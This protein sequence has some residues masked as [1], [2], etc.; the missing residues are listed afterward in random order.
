ML[1]SE[2]KEGRQTNRGKWIMILLGLARRWDGLGLDML[3]YIEL[4]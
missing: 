3:G 1:K 2:M 4:S